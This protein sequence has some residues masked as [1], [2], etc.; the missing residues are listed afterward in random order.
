MSNLS[1]FNCQIHSSLH[2][3]SLVAVCGIVYRFICRDADNLWWLLAALCLCVYLICAK[4]STQINNKCERTNLPHQRATTFMPRKYIPIRLNTR[5][6][7]NLFCSRNSVF[8]CLPLNKNSKKDDTNTILYSFQFSL[9][10]YRLYTFTY[11]YNCVYY[12]IARAIEVSI[13]H[14]EYNAIS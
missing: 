14:K 9:Y 12:F 1:P 10:T 8:V 11:F 7:C 3:K 4:C 6:I 13:K 2:F 5:Y